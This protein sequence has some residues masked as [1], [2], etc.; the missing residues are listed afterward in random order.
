MRYPYPVAPYEYL[1][2]RRQK[3]Q[4]IPLA[5]DTIKRAQDAD[6]ESNVWFVYAHDPTLYGVVDFLPSFE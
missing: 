3:T 5:I 2:I 4:D 6:A 1:Q